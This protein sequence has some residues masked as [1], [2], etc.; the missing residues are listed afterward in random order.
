MQVLYCSQD[1]PLLSILIT[2][3]VLIYA[4]T[5]SIAMHYDCSY[6]PLSTTSKW[7]R[8]VHWRAYGARWQLLS[9]GTCSQFRGFLEPQMM[10]GH[11][12]HWKH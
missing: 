1:T 5:T 12:V 9:D 11:S 2:V 7:W 8:C 4:H 6:P 3:L 10:D